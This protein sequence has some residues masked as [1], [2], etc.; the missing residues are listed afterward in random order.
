[1]FSFQPCD[2]LVFGSPTTRQQHQIV[3]DHSLL[4]TNLLSFSSTSREDQPIGTPNLGSPPPPPR[5][6]GQARFG[7]YNKRVLHRDIERKRREE[8]SKLCVSLNTLLPVENNKGKS[9]VSDQ[10]EEAT[11]YIKHMHEKMEGLQ[12]RRDK[13]KKS[14]YNSSSSRGANVE[15]I[16]DGSSS[17]LHNSVAVHRNMD[18]LEII[19]T[20]KSP[21][22]ELS[23][24]LA[25]LL[26]RELDVVSCVST[27][28]NGGFL[29]TIVTKASNRSS[30][31][32]WGLH[33][34]LNDT[35]K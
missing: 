7:S 24:V 28:T 17:R 29:H 20:N 23:H 8:M 32:V 18:G 19:I 35:I 5:Q 2:E 15:I 33:D 22:F 9:S 10:M 27:A 13:L 4:E 30:L 31:D 16:S 12:T 11:K 26:Q 6:K 34:R 14:Y 21:Q 3:M 25:Q 1:M